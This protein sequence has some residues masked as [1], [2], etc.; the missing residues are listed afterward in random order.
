MCRK[1][2]CIP[3][4]GAWPPAWWSTRRAWRLLIMAA[5]GT[6]AWHHKTA[7]KIMGEMQNSYPKF[8]SSDQHKK[9]FFFFF[10]F[11]F[12]CFRSTCNKLLAHTPAAGCPTSLHQ[13][14]IAAFFL[15]H[16]CNKIQLWI[17]FL[18][19]QVTSINKYTKSGFWI[20][21]IRIK[22]LQLVQLPIK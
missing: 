19:V 14:L 5:G 3:F 13:N 18:S 4:A 11:S 20:F 17:S 7:L 9:S 2:Y 16:I 1:S 21:Q 15:S 22:W 8:S 6:A 10:F 12:F